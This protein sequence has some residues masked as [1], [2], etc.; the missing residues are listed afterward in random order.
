[1]DKTYSFAVKEVCRHPRIMGA[2]LVWPKD[3]TSLGIL[4][5]SERYQMGLRAVWNVMV[6]I[7]SHTPS[8]SENRRRDS[9]GESAFLYL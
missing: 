5:V 4:F 7:H 2:A 6:D 3:I 1:M 8:R 9:F